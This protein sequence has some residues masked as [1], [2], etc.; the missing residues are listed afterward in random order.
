MASSGL[1][2]NP[3][4]LAEHADDFIAAIGTPIGLAASGLDAA[5][6]TALTDA[7]T[8]LRTAVDTRSAA[9]VA[10]R[11]AVEAAEGQHATAEALY[12]SLRQAANN[13]TGM[14]DNLRAQ[15]RLTIRD[16]E[17][18]P[19]G[20]PPEIMDLV[21]TAHASGTN[22]LDWTG[23][24]ERGLR[25]E[26]FTASDAAGPWTLIGSATTSA[27]AHHEAGAGV[28]RHYR[29]IAKRGDEEGLPSNEASVYV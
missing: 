17:P 2:R 18:T 29:V 24:T 4:A 10:Y 26:V 20:P 1:P 16:T 25:Y 3:L 8:A 14:T 6:I 15:A 22:F 7:M 12:R 27:F 28:T 13:S 5:Q 9:E 21:A 23:P 19:A 11:A